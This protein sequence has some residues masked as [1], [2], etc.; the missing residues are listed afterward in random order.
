ML[1]QDPSKINSALKLRN[2]DIKLD[3]DYFPIPLNLREPY[4]TEKKFREAM[5]VL[6]GHLD[7][8]IMCHGYV[9]NESIFETNMLEWD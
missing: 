2:P 3:R 6:G 9:K 1:V 4:Q 7:C 8:L 5:K